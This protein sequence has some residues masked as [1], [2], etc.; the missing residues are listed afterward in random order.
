MSKYILKLK[1]AW[2]I[3]PQF[4]INYSFFIPPTRIIFA[5]DFIIN[6]KLASHTSY[7]NTN[8]GDTMQRDTPRVDFSSRVCRLRKLIN[9]KQLNF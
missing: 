4:G 6:A 3:I 1:T 7:G 5:V 9:L 8:K 2:N